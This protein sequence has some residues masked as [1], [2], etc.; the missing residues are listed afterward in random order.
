LSPDPAARTRRDLADTEAVFKALAHASRRHILLVLYFR[1][2]EMS[3]GDIAQR[4]SCSWPTT[5]R[6]LRILEEAGLVKA[7]KRG[8]ERVYTLQCAR[9]LEVTSRWLDS[10]RSDRPRP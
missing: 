9:L 8:R 4:F 5:T 1:G 10:F 2:G 3:A 6:H 7:E